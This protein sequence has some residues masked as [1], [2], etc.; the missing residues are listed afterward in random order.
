MDRIKSK[1][2]ITVTREEK[3]AR[4]EVTVMLLKVSGKR[5][6]GGEVPGLRP[7]EVGFLV[8]SQGWRQECESNSESNKGEKWKW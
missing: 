7:W 3:A 8:T 5:G 1:A 2:S 4:R 6:S